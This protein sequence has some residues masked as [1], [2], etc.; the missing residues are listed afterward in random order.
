L[1]TKK[2]LIFVSNDLFSLLQI[3]I[4]SLFES[5]FVI[6]LQKSI[7]VM[8]EKVCDAN[9]KL[10]DLQHHKKSRQTKLEK[11]KYNLE[12]MCL[13]NGTDYNVEKDQQIRRIQND[14]DKASIKLG[15][16]QNI[17]R[18]YEAI[19]DNLQKVCHETRVTC[20][21]YEALVLWFC[22]LGTQ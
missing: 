4:H 3:E 5:N 1:L 13:I 19:M 2:P 15:A 9:K 18:R 10:N 14:M 21:F 11:L 6:K 12:E 17:T 8:D 22:G 20:T 16:A 7:T